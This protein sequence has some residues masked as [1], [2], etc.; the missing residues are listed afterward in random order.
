M[1]TAYYCCRVN[2][3]IANIYVS[4]GVAGSSNP[5]LRAMHPIWE[6]YVAFEYSQ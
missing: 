6:E 1:L 3:F 2:E 4:M 5:F